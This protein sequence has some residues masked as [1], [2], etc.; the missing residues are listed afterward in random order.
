MHL[1]V[2]KDHSALKRNGKKHV[3]LPQV[4]PN[5]TKPTYLMASMVK[6]L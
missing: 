5:T 4:R 6:N 3:Y 1:K 2:E